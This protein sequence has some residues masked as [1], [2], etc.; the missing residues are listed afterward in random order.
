[1]EDSD[2]FSNISLIQASSHLALNSLKQRTPQKKQSKEPKQKVTVFQKL[3]VP[4]ENEVIRQ[5][6]TTPRL[7]N[8]RQIEDAKTET[9][10]TQ[11]D[12]ISQYFNRHY[13]VIR[14]QTNKNRCLLMS[15]SPARSTS[16]LS[17]SVSRQ[18]RNRSNTSKLAKNA[19]QSAL[20]QY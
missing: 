17:G 4:E 20:R 13:E 15:K 9:L 11:P 1:M 14:Q 16:N 7:T 3:A 18:P 8:Q 10:A 5:A 19:S 12:D 2:N 6:V